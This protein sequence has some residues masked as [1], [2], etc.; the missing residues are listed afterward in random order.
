MALDS[1]T[2][3]QNLIRKRSVSGETDQGAL[4]VLQQALEGMGFN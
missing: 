4:D 1:V 3:S 2:L